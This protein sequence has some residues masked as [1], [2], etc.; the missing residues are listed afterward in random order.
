MQP[1]GSFVKNI[2]M[3]K[4]FEVIRKCFFIYLNIFA[5]QKS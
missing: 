4:F 2:Y 1:G 5:G 3:I